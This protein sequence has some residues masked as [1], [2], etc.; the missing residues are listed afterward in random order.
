METSTPVPRPKKHKATPLAA[1]ALIASAVTLSGCT[2]EAGPGDG[3]STSSLSVEQSPIMNGY[4]TT[5]DQALLTIEVLTVTPTPKT[6]YAPAPFEIDQDLLA[7]DAGWAETEVA[8]ENCTIPN[9]TLARD[10]VNAV[11]DADTCE[12]SGGEW[13]DPLSGQTADRDSV[14]ARPFLP[15]ERAWSSGA[16]SWTDH[17]FS[18]YRN[19]PQS[20]MTISDESYE[21]RGQRGPDQW[22]PEDRGLWCGYALRWV[23]E[24]NTF[25][26]SMETQSE[27]EALTEMLNTCPEQGFTHQS[28]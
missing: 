21:E 27:S 18:I 17:Q 22:R 1:A 24:K 5:R 14:E 7:R 26:L 25:G 19:S 11:V 23:S 3:D 16:N 20:V 9:A 10:G 13:F 8:N 4:N 2:P 28:A 6:G 15:T 12:V